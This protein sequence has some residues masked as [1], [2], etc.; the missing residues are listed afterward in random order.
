VS[1]RT[2]HRNP[3]EWISSFSRFGVRP[4]LERMEF[5]LERLGRPHDSLSFIHVAGTNGKGSTCS[6]FASCFMEEGYA[7][8]L[9]TSPYIHSFH[10]RMS[11]QGIEVSDGELGELVGELEPHVTKMMESAG[12]GAPTEFEIVTLLALLYFSRKQ[13]DVIV[14]ETGLGGRLDATNVVRPI[15]SVITNIGY[16][17]LHILG[18]TLEEIASEKA[19]IIKPG[20]PVVTGAVEPALSV[21]RK[22]AEETK[23]PLRVAGEDFWYQRVSYDERGQRFDFMT[24]TG[25]RMPYTISLLGEHQCANAALA[26][27]GMHWLTERGRL[28]ISER[29][30]RAGLAGTRWPGRMETVCRD[31]LVIL[32]GAHN[33]DGVEALVKTLGE[34]VGNRPIT[35]VL[36]ILADKINRGMLEPLAR[37]A[38]RI[39][40]TTPDNPRSADPVHVAEALQQ[41]GYRNPLEIRPT[42]AGALDAAV[43]GMRSSNGVIV[44]TGSLY[45]VSA[46]RNHIKRQDF[47]CG[48]G[49]GSW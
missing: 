27:A 19:G 18:S 7:V 16:D 44:C 1:E 28:A 13:P 10:E 36:G 22:A 5:L 21:I 23:A 24:K 20:V 32:D 9:Y 34:L 47:S 33:I 25:V 4:G 14:W 12:L 39:I 37:I 15:L 42:I 41:L 11:V 40:V 45:T 49:R 48:E 6:F 17:H 31:P 35:I 3:L 8:G 2:A 30:I 38:D 46:A 26:V 43:Q 29:A